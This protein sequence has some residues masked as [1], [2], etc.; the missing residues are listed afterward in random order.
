[1]NE[2]PKLQTIRRIAVDALNFEP[3]TSP[4]VGIAVKLI[5]EIELLKSGLRSV[6]GRVSLTFAKGIASETLKDAERIEE[7]I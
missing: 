6:E 3:E 2:T 1:M 4:F 5:D 7:S